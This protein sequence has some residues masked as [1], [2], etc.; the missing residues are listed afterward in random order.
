M[1][2]RLIFFLVF[3][4]T[5][6]LAAQQYCIAG[7]F[8]QEPLFADGVL[9]ADTGVVYGYAYNPFAN[10][11]QALVIDI[12]YP[13]T[14]A[15]TMRARPF[16]LFIHGG[17]FAAG[18]RHDNEYFCREYARR[19]YVAATMDYRLG[20]LCKSP[21]ACNGCVQDSLQLRQATYMAVQ[22]ARAALRFISGNA[23]VY[24]VSPSMIFLEGTSAGSITA[25]LAALW[26]Q[27]LAN[28]F[29]PGA[30]T[31][32]GSLDTAGNAFRNSYSIRAISDN[33]GAVAGDSATLLRLDIPVISFHDEN[34]CMVPYGPGTLFGCGCSSFYS[35]FGPQAIYDQLVV[36]GRCAELN[37]AP[38]SPFHCSWPAENLMARSS[39]FFKRVMCNECGSDTNSNPHAVAPCDSLESFFEA[40]VDN[41]IAMLTS[42]PADDRAEIT[43]S[44]FAE[45]G[46]TVHCL[47]ALGRPVM[48]V[49]F[50]ATAKKVEIDTHLL[51][52]G[53][54]FLLFESPGELVGVKLAVSR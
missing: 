40:G 6:P 43:F 7:R 29:A 4:S 41:F 50:A 31:L 42:S 34:D 24:H 33:C 28:A 21:D 2:R 9:R 46:G 51:P 19:G 15:D 37:T 20:W 26:D 23:A 25:F 48:D 35:C 54:Y 39:C 13:D 1:L 38:G 32:L 17:G 3:F 47:D 44:D 22:D 36:N 30:E 5:L 11:Q 8:S 52:P 53:L 49:S 12:F 18:T 45:H 10:A 16:I 14:T 27:Q